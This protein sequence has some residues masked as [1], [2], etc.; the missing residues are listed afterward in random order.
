MISVDELRVDYGNLCAVEELSFSVAEGEVF[1]L[2]GPNGAGKTSTMRALVGL[3]APTYGA[4]NIAGFDVREEPQ[5]VGQVLGFMPDFPPVYEDLLV[6]EFLDLFAASYFIPK[7]RRQSEIVHRLEQVGLTEKTNSLV[8][9]LSRGMRQRLMLAK[10]LL[11]EPKVLLLDEPASGMDPHGRAQ[12]KQVIRDFAENGGTVLV[13]SHILSEMDEFCTSIGIMERGEMILTGKVDEIAA[14][15]LG[16][17]VLEV[18]LVS[19]TDSLLKILAQHRIDAEPDDSNRRFEIP[20]DGDDNAAS[21]LLAEFVN[22]GVRVSSFSRKH[23][24]LE[25]VF[26]QIGAKELS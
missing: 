21:D 16:Q 6:W 15:V 12:M 14:K 10:T 5:A 9:S 1:G 3:L 11:P 8:G 25:D 26:L 13:S 23:E 24:S 22:A 7:P 20:F 18:E 19:G 4:I 17:S 2:I